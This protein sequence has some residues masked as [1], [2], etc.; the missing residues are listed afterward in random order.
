ME[1]QHH[2]VYDNFIVDRSRV[3]T[4][5]QILFKRKFLDFNFNKLLNYIDEQLKVNTG[6][7]TRAQLFNLV[8]ILILRQKLSYGTSNAPPKE[9]ISR[10][11]VLVLTF[12]LKR[13][14]YKKDSS[15]F[16]LKRR[17]RDCFLWSDDPNNPDKFWTINIRF[18][19][20]PT[21]PNFLSLLKTKY[22]FYVLGLTTRNLVRRKE[23]SRYKNLDL[24]FVYS[25]MYNYSTVRTLFKENRDDWFYSYYIWK[26]LPNILNIDRLGVRQATYFLLY[27]NSRLVKSGRSNQDILFSLL[28]IYEF[29]PFSIKSW[30]RKSIVSYDYNDFTKLNQVFLASLIPLYEIPLIGEVEPILKKFEKRLNPSKLLGS[31]KLDNSKINDLCESLIYQNKDRVFSILKADDKI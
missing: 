16:F 10:S 30:I 26:Y 18:F 28:G 25:I 4:E 6:I 15:V 11:S 17:M 29:S 13:D 22:L 23:K 19:D 12:S 27:V 9:V 14:S 7:R 31:L 1:T 5:N 21:F 20:D 3:I 8:N 2:K 24:S